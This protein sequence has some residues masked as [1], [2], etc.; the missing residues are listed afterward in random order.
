M[1][2]RDFLGTSAV[3]LTA[4]GLAGIHSAQGASNNVKVGMCDWNVRSV[5]NPKSGGVCNPELIQDAAAVNLEGIQVSVGYVDRKNN[6]T[7][8]PLRDPNVRKQYIELGKKH[9][10]TFCSVAAGSI[11]NSIPIATEPESGIYVLDAVE[12]AAALGAK[13]IL[14]AFFGNGDLRLTDYTGRMRNIS[15]GPFKEYELDTQ[16]V[17]RVVRLMKQL[18]PRAEDLG[19]ALGLENTISAKQNLEIIERVGSP[20]LQVYYDI[21]NSWGNGYDVPNEI[22]MLGNDRICEIHLKDWNTKL[23]GSSEGMIEWNAVAQACKAINF[24]KWYVIENSG[25]KPELYVEDT[26]A[27]VAFA[28]RTLA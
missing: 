19:V 1:L 3:G 6:E 5:N 9:G 12:A 21:G 2:R 14:M 13:N 27:N 26:K 24:D 23:F 18:A 20:I 11:C 15:E 7:V 17:S 8:I 28:K 22:R 16:K 25:R 10:I 4:L